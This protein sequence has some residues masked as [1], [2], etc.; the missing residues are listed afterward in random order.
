MP[1]RSHARSPGNIAGEP[2]SW[3]A[4][5]AAEKEAVNA[6]AR[7]KEAADDAEKATGLAKVAGAKADKLQK[8]LQVR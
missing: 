5:Q 6:A 3:Q 2:R 4:T 7:A 8:D 1:A